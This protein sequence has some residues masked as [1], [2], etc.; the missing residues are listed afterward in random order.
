MRSMRTG[1][2]QQ[3]SSYQLTSKMNGP[4]RT[5]SEGME[6]PADTTLR[7]LYLSGSAWS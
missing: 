5:I 2:P 7:L 1:F 6:T 4:S 3:V